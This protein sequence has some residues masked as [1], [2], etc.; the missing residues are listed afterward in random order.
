MIRSSLRHTSKRTMSWRYCFVLALALLGATSALALDPNKHIT[1]Y[2]HAAWRIQDGF[3]RTSPSAF[4]Q[5]PDGYLWIGTFS[6]LLRF[7]G[8]R[9]VPWNPEPGGQMLSPSV[10]QLLVARDG[11]LWIA[12]LGGLSRWKD[13]ILT[14]Y[15]AGT[16]GGSFVFEDRKG[17]IWFPQG[18]AP[19]DAKPLCEVVGPGTRCYGSAD[20]VPSFNAA[21][22]VEDQE[23]NL[24]FGGYTSLL[25]WDSNSPGVYHLPKP[26]TRT[27]GIWALASASGTLWVG[28]ASAGPGLGLLRFTEGHWSTFQTHLFD[29]SNL[30]A[31]ALYTDREGALWVGTYDQGVYRIR[32]NE[33]D[34]FGST[35]GLSSDHV[36]R[37]FEDREG[38]L[39]VATSLGV[40]RF[41]DTPVVSLTV[42]EG[43]CCSEASSI[44]ASR[45]GSIW[46]GGDG[47]LTNL[48][49]GIV[50]CLRAGK[51]LPGSRVTSLLEDHAGRLWAGID[52]NL[53]VRENGT[54]RRIKK[55]DGSAV[56]FVTGITEDTE[57]KVWV[58]VTTPRRIIMR[59]EG[60]TVRQESQEP[61]APRKLAADPTGGIWVGLLN[62]DLAHIRDGKYETYHFA[63]D[64][65]AVVNQLLPLSDGSVLAATT[66]GMVA[67]SEGRQ[68][69]LNATNG[70]PC[71][72]TN[73]MA[74][75]GQGNLWLFMSCGLGQ[76]MRADLQ[77]WLRNPDSTVAIKSLDVLDGVF[78]GR[79]IFMGAATSTDGR[80]WFANG[81]FVQTIDP[82][83]IH[84]DTVPPPVHIEQVIADRK[85]YSPTG[86]VRLPA[87]TRDL[88]IDY[89]GLSYSVPQ[90]V[91]F[92]YRLEGRDR[93][94]Q[95][96]GI[97]RQAFYNDLRPGPYRFR[98]IACN[99]DGL[100][101]EAG[102]ALE[103]VVAPAFY[104]TIWFQTSG[105]IAF[106]AFLWGLYR[107][108][109]HQMA[110]QLNLRL[111]ERVTER[112]RIAREL[113]DT[114]LQ[115][116]QGL[117][118]RFQAVNDLLPEG[119]TKDQLEQTLQRGDQA[120]AEGRTAVYDLRSSTLAT[121]NL[122]QAV[123]SLG[124][125]LATPD[126]PPF[127]L[128][129]E[130]DPKDLYPII[131]D[132]IYRI[133]RE[134]LRN[135]FLHAE[136][137]QI[138][139]EIIYGER[140]LRLRIR[141]DGKGVP[142]DVLK[143]GRHGH[144]GLCGMRERAQQIGGKLDIWSQ[145]GAGTEIEL[146]VA[147]AIAYRSFAG[148]SFRGLFRKKAG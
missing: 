18:L 46:T 52:D 54:F 68:L 45:D 141:D 118:L 76:M 119:K 109:L 84:R 105:A 147:S 92:R 56:G 83:H 117:M 5:T 129:V 69:Y 33:V 55:P 41:A 16:S 12:S 61:Y 3:F 140:E 19:E 135:A 82:A 146:S 27:K 121:N 9:F 116:F 72:A 15:P 108:R 31:E 26:V 143:E 99:S 112:T 32:G 23:G 1:Q 53:W 65:A 34:H 97:R 115:S 113:H 127:R 64:D 93:T 35:D 130:G 107:Y 104:Q 58:T 114:L 17:R 37:F 102:A 125:E 148:F 42:K 48:R 62:G 10:R 88:E 78:A 144:Y 60:L 142:S 47:A 7:D 85:S 128:V 101:N 70:L 39:W 57:N 79:A 91:L 13:H 145:P 133:A 86:V 11:S 4:A 50:S 73:A 138:E 29:G 122:V 77:M 137:R 95:E 98:V 80:L 38:N 131:R 51:G 89:V 49:D 94:W 63:H 21:S 132:E 66:Y 44:L 20:G 71:E 134:A 28:T 74:F 67:W 124:A 43:L 36:M 25:R 136:A 90:K 106:L 96:A 87:L 40:D 110:H 81:D 111:E 120:I 2:A 6:G 139:T 30:V 22:A 24:W 123:K 59:I 100:W 103:L 8:V 14:N 75:D 126:S